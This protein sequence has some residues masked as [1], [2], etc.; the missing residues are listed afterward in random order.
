[1]GHWIAY[2]VSDKFRFQLEL[3]YVPVTNKWLARWKTRYIE[4]GL[5]S[6]SPGVVIHDYKV[7]LGVPRS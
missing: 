3:S 7:D 6:Y 4:N 5:N 1:M 2:G